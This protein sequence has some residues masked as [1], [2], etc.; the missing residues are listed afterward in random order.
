MTDD[1]Y[2]RGRYTVKGS[3]HLRDV[4]ISEAFRKPGSL[5]RG[6]P[7]AYATKHRSYFFC[8]KLSIE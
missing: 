2:E 6:Y 3:V 8:A 4:R 1:G 7:M 5:L